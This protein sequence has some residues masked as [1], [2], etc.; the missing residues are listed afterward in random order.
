MVRGRQWQKDFEVDW[1]GC[2]SSAPG[3]LGTVV[4]ILT[5]RG[6]RF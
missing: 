3:G 2:G 4:S 5:M 1:N 6:A